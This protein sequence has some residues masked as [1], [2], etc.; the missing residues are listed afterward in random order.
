MECQSNTKN[1]EQVLV[2][3]FTYNQSSVN[4]NGLFPIQWFTY[5]QSNGYKP[6]TNMA[7]VRARRC[8]LIKRCTRLAAA[9]DKA[10]QLLAHGSCCS[11]GYSETNAYQYLH[12]VFLFENKQVLNICNVL[13]KWS[14]YSNNGH[15]LPVCWWTILTRYNFVWG[16]SLCVM[17]CS[18]IKLKRSC[19]LELKYCYNKIEVMP[20]F[21]NCIFF[22]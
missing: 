14:I 8:T 9:S 10:Y 18:G 2:Q 15:V 20:L 13:P 6:I 4:N 3:W 17:V 12:F 1:N 21:N 7:W 19:G 11:P 16:P 5:C 22:Q